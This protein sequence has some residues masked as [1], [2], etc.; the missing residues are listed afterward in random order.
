MPYHRASS[1]IHPAVWYR[2]QI[3][4][5]IRQRRK[6]IEMI[7]N[8]E[9]LTPDMLTMLLTINTPRDIT[10]KIADEHHT[11]PLTDDEVRGNIL[12]VI[13]AGVDTVRH[14]FTVPYVDQVI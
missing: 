14:F 4:E 8:D 5:L 12:E 1:R 9:Q 11:R 2:P 7:T 6:E 13:S 3:D 10:V